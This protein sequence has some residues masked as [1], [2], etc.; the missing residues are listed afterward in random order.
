MRHH[1]NQYTRR[2]HQSQHSCVD[3]LHTLQW[4]RCPHLALT[5]G[6]RICMVLSVADAT[7]SR[8]RPS[9]SRLLYT[10]KRPPVCGCVATCLWGPISLAVPYTSVQR[11]CAPERLHGEGERARRTSRRRPAGGRIVGSIKPAGP[12]ARARSPAALGADGDARHILV[13]S[14]RTSVGKG[15][16]GSDRSATFTCATQTDT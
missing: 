11:A 4:I 16:S 9:G 5:R 13:L 8:R 3:V 6:C 12:L 15:L 7:G 1:P 14:D 10:H 2:A